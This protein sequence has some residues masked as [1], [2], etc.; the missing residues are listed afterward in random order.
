M[1][2]F[3]IVTSL[4][5]VVILSLYVNLSSLQKIALLFSVF[6]FLKLI[7]DLGNT[8]PIKSMISF[9]LLVQF[10]I[11]P[12]ITYRYFENKA[13]F[14]MYVQEGIY[15]F[16]V[17]PAV[18]CF[19]LGLN[20]P[21]NKEKLSYQNAIQVLPDAIKLNGTN[22]AILL[23]IIGFLGS[24]VGNFMPINSLFFL[25]YLMGLFRF[26]GAFML[27][28]SNFR[29]KYLLIAFVFIQ[30]SYEIISGG[31]F[32]DLFVWL[33]FLF[34]LLEFKWKSS[35]IRKLVFVLVGGLT[36]YFIQSFKK[37]YRNE[38]WGDP[39]ESSRTEVFVDLASNQL[40][41][42][43]LLDDKSTLDAFVSRLNTGWIVSKVMQ[44]TP[45]YEPFAN[46]ELLKEDLINVFLPRFLFPNKAMTGG[47]ENQEKF[48]KYT[49]RRLIG[50]TTM[51]IG[52]I[53]DAYVNF[54]V[55]GGWI[56]LFCLG[57]VFNLIL[58]FMISR[59]KRNSFYILWIPFVF[60]YAVRMSDIQVILNY[61]IKALFIVIIVNYLFFNRKVKA[62][63]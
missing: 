38:I 62:L 35:F 12:L 6:F 34:M 47:S 15:F 45:L 43:D 59:S 11:S 22:K 50:S 25:F 31:V 57:F 60:A 42:S 8:I 40:E 37:D 4:L 20:L 58:Y 27:F 5:V 28:F 14:S 3:S 55:F 53:S 33:F 52:A 9:L 44:H 61:T 29:Y 7:K 26:V 2:Y 21:I 54:G 46:G 1:K 16:Y 24:V 41:Q 19:I 48:T 13:S 18:L 51:R 10:F 56:M 36:V 63:D 23:I 32:Y 49:G 39:T 17:I 30:F